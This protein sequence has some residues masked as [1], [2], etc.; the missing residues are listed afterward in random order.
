MRDVV[1]TALDDP[2]H[3]QRLVAYIVARQDGD[4]TSQGAK[5]SD[6]ARQRVEGVPDQIYTQRTRARI[7]LQHHWLEQL[8]F[9]REPLPDAEM[10]GVG[11]TER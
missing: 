1:L 8:S 5:R 4:E 2:E 6:G 10:R 3:G 11:G 7:Q 9:T